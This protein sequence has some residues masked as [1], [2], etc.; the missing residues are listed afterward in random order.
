MVTPRL[1][2]TAKTSITFFHLLCTTNM[3]FSTWVI[4]IS[5]DVAA[6]FALSRVVAW[7]TVR[8]DL[9]SYLLP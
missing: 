2:E 7:A 5:A 4:S 3:A 6:D 1:E 8:V 9:E